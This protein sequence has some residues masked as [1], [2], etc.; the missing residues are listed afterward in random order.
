MSDDE[1]VRSVRSGSESPTPEDLAFINDTGE[2][3]NVEEECTG[4][5]TAGI[6]L[7]NIIVGPRKRKRAKHWVHP[8]QAVVDAQFCQDNGL[9]LD[10]MYGILNGDVYATGTTLSESS[11]DYDPN[12]DADDDDDDDEPTEL[13]ESDVETTTDHSW[14]RKY[15]R[16]CRIH[17]V[18]T[19]CFIVLHPHPN[20]PPGAIPVAHHLGGSIASP[21]RSRVVFGESRPPLRRQR[22]LVG[23]KRFAATEPA[24]TRFESRRCRRR[25]TCRSSGRRRPTSEARVGVFGHKVGSLLGRCSAYSSRRSS[26]RFPSAMVPSRSAYCQQT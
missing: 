14:R 24:V 2:D 9:E 26:R 10:E 8:D 16:L 20:H 7:S 18:T 1:D 19:V 5:D 13:E 22:G 3:D 11:S 4:P 6:D 23:G 25:C 12:E 21:R 17:H 15:Q